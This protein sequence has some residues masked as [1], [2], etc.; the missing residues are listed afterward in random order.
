M[1]TTLMLVL[2]MCSFSVNW[3]EKRVVKKVLSGPVVLLKKN[4]NFGMKYIFP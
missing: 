2:F 4:N 3:T 1:S